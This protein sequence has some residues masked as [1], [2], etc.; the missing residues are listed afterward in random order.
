MIILG[1]SHDSAAC[2]RSRYI[3]MTP[4]ISYAAQTQL[5]FRWMIVVV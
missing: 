1:E 2:R 4:L 3:I 5:Q